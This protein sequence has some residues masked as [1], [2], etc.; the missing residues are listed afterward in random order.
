[1]MLTNGGDAMMLSTLRLFVTLTIAVFAASLAEAQQTANI[2]RLCF[3][4]AYPVAVAA[5]G[6]QY[7]VFLRGL[8]DVGYVEGQSI[9]IDYLSAD[10]RIERFP[11]LAGECLRLQADI[12]VAVTTPASL[13]AKHATRTIPIVLLGTGDPVRTGLVDSLARPG[14]NV[15]GLSH[16]APGLSAKRL[17]LL[18]EAVPRI[19]RVVVLSNLAD[20]VATPQVQ[21]LEQAARSMGVQLQIRD[22]RTPEELPPAFSTAATDGAEGLLTTVE[23][24]FVTHRTQVVDLAARHR[25]PAIYPWRVFVDAGGLMSYGASGV[26]LWRRAVYYVDRILKGAKPGEL[27]IEQPTKFDVVINLKTA[28]ALGITIPPHLLVMADEVIR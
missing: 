19:S 2:P 6:G 24:I 28:K 20:P 9:I 1:M 22:V 18:K 7:E 26:D 25:L 23:S 5:I 4:H 8:R 3:L 13:A 12:I 16:M 27:P 21:E 17:E 15:T 10:G 11:T 14:G